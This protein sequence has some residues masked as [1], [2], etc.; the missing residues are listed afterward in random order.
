MEVKD[1]GRIPSR[2][3]SMA[4]GLVLVFVAFKEVIAEEKANW[5][6]QQVS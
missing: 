1:N 3:Q 6:K 2:R 4:V 5:V